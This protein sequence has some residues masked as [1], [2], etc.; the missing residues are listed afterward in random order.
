MNTSSVLYFLLKLALGFVFALGLY[1]GLKWARKHPKD[2]N[3]A[4]EREEKKVSVVNLAMS[5]G[6][7]TVS[8]CVILVVTVIGTFLALGSLILILAYVPPRLLFIAAMFWL[9]IFFGAVRIF[10]PLVVHLMDRFN[11]TKEGAIT[12]T[13]TYRQAIL[14]AIFMGV[15]V[16]VIGMFSI[17]VFGPPIKWAGESESFALFST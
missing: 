6:Q 7:L 3:I 8:I 14:S 1:Y 2:R 12:P 17:P 11:F 5:M 15:L 10:M 9:V 16:I 4:S 13:I